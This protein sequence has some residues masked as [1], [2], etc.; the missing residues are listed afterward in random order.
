M[1][2]LTV[3]HDTCKIH[4]KYTLSLLGGKSSHL[5]TF[6]E[7]LL[8]VSLKIKVYCPL[9]FSSV[10][11][12]VL[13]YCI[14]VIYDYRTN[15]PKTQQLETINIYCLTHFLRATNLGSDLLYVS[16]LEFHR[17]GISHRWQSLHVPLTE[18]F[19]TRLTQIQG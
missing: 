18:L 6:K 7:K 11:A 1:N 12:A 8:L 10:S 9:F 19:G 14:L 4:V 3:L 13:R 15:Q 17:E 2:C 16:D 5:Y